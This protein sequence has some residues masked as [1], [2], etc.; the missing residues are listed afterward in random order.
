MSGRAWARYWSRRRLA[1][2]GSARKVRMLVAMAASV[3]SSSSSKSMTGTVGGVGSS[4]PRVARYSGFTVRR[5]WPLG[6]MCLDG[7]GDQLSG[8]EEE[9]ES[10]ESDHAE[11]DPLDG[12]EEACVPVGLAKEGQEELCG[13]CGGEGEGGGVA[14]VVAVVELAEEDDGEKGCCDCGVEG[15]GVK[16]GGARWDCYGPGEGGG[17]AGVGA[18][19]EMAEGEEGPD[20]GGAGGP[21]VES[22]EEREIAEAEVDRCRDDGEENA[23]GGEG[24][25]H[26]QEYGVGDEAVG[27]GDDQQEAGEREGEEEGEEAGVPE[28]VG[29]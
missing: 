19:G 2:A 1:A 15:Y 5:R 3:S 13:A 21:S 25:H 22:V 12:V 11:G 23:V 10:G 20:E 29:D 24:G 16:A 9:D 27:V 18:F 28:L 8:L 26:K 6:S 17:K 14:R 7:M 4:T